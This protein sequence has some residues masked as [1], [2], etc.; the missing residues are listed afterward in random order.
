MQYRIAILGS[1]SWA[2][3]LAK[4]VLTNQSEIN[5]FIRRQEVIDEFAAT[6]KNPS[7]LG[8]A[9]FDVSRIHFSTDINKVVSQSDVLIVAI[10]SPYVKQSLNKIRRNMTRKIVISAVKGM[11]PDDNMLVTDYLH[12]RFRIPTD[13]LG[14]I[15]GPCHAEE[16]A[17][18]RLSYLTIGCENLDKANEWA[19]LFQTP[20][21]H[22]ATSN[23]VLGLEYSSVMKNIYAI[24]A[25]MCQSL[26]YGDN[27]QAVLL[28][29][30]MQEILRFAT[31]VS[32]THRD[33]TASGYL[34]DV[35]V[36]AYS[37][38]SR[39]RQFGQ[40]VGLGYS[41]KAAQMEMEMVAE[42]YYGTRAIHIANER[43]QVSLPIV[44][45]MYDILYNRKS[46]TIVIRQLT[47][48]L[49]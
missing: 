34:G 28:T 44:D 9:E 5:W 36:T 41:I 40:M 6:G 39:N 24:A 19:T 14:I 3:A 38:F 8:A 46:P 15:A 49:Q 12:T 20:F 31:A 23:D 18:E 43:M 1:G 42:G 26:H 37:K 10:P 16:I 13:Q 2:T 7:Y 47:E 29:N 32:N 30:A 45:A 4:I 48:K 25:G 33:I 35:L 21:V 22:T 27:F 17:L 11:I